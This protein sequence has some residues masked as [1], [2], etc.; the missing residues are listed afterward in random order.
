MPKTVDVRLVTCAELPVPDPDTPLLAAALTRAG[1]SVDVA[2]WRD[3]RV[4]W[5]AARVTVLRSPWDYVDHLDEFLAWAE[6]VHAVSDLWNPVALVRWNTH[7]AYL[8][9]LHERGAPV[10]PTVV[11]LGGSAA[12]LDGICDAQGWNSVVVKP[13]V[14]SGSKGARRAE[15]GDAGAQAHL[16]ELLTRGDALVQQFVPG[17]TDEGEWSVIL[18]DGE[19]SHALRK[20]PASGDYRVQEEWGGTTERAEPGASL[21]ELATRVCSVLPAAALY[22]RI[23]VVLLDD[24]WHVMEVE[25][26]EPALWLDLAPETTQRL[27]D[28]I[29]VRL[30]R[31]Q[32]GGPDTPAKASRDGGSQA[33]AG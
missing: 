22:A 32:I 21:V 12:S 17:I 1:H 5:A 3:A 15:V 25:V 14:A 20:R 33:V 6:R 8:L 27:A 26:T 4:D 28:A 2:D 30:A 11:L 18:V 7:K 9:E 16:D 19:L 29:G 10:V 13:A 24:Q 31:A 23:D